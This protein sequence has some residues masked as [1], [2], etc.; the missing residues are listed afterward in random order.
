MVTEKAS[1]SL[2]VPQ[3]VRLSIIGKWDRQCS[4]ACLSDGFVPCSLLWSALFRFWPRLSFFVSA[5]GSWTS[6]HNWVGFRRSV[7][8]RCSIWWCLSDGQPY[9][10]PNAI[11][12]LVSEWPSHS[13]FL[14]FFRELDAPAFFGRWI[15][16][17]R[18][19]CHKRNLRKRS[20]LTIQNLQ[21]PQSCSPTRIQFYR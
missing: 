12:L 21:K 4:W 16:V 11:E 17:T 10:R 13:R 14:K 20:I 7:P 5:G 2:A 15:M 19:W 8:W 3:Q 6:F 9:Q 18:C 1:V